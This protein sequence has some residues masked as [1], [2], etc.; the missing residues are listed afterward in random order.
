MVKWLDRRSVNWFDSKTMTYIEMCIRSGIYDFIRSE[1]CM[2]SPSCR[3]DLTG[4][5]GKETPSQESPFD[6][7]GEC[8]EGVKQTNKQT[9]MKGTH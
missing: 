9:H 7:I 1:E 8:I 2:Q 6:C 5:L 4:K 3:W